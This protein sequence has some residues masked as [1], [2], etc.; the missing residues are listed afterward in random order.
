MKYT[1]ETTDNSSYVVAT[2]AKGEE[3]D[4]SQLDILLTNDLKNIIKPVRKSVNESILIY[5]N[6]TSKISL[7]QATSGRKVPKNGFINIIEGALSA[8]EDIDNHGLSGSGIVFDEK[9]VYVKAGTY[10]PCFMY[11]PCTTQNTGI[12]PLKKFIIALIMDCKIEKIND[13]FIQTLFD[14][15][16]NPNLCA[17]DLRQFCNE[18]TKGR[19]SAA[20]LTKNARFSVITPTMIDTESEFSGDGKKKAEPK[21]PTL[22]EASNDNHSEKKDEAHSPNRGKQKKYLFLLLQLCIIVIIAVISK[23]GFFDNPDGTFNIKYLLG[24]IAGLAVAD[25]VIYRELFMNAQTIKNEDN[26][27]H[28]TH[29]DSESTK[30]SSS[31]DKTKTSTQS[32]SHPTPSPIQSVPQSLEQVYAGAQGSEFD[33]TVL[34]DE[35]KSCAHLEFFEN[36]LFKKIELNKDVVT[37]GKLSS[38]C[39]YAISNNK[40]SKLH[41]EFIVRENKYFV[42]D[43]NSTNGTYINGNTQRISSNVE[44]QIHDGD[45]I[46]L[47]NVELT[48][49][50]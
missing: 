11:L 32:Q 22:K 16:N 21:P 19:I 43:C 7:E 48:F 6:I 41:A 50:C 15:L 5:Y 33:D 26:N 24:I 14:T 27:N 34:L 10:E 40:I 28:K 25:I 46:T 36:G 1:Y 13:G 35:E 47:A 49:K 3:T 29:S 38:Q 20:K 18:Q 39:D 23:S 17:N 9:N 44:H 4:N 2:F 42:R 31:T 30:D 37:V 45:H 8:L 12:E